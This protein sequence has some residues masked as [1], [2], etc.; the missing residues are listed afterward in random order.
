M[1]QY[2]VLLF[3]S[4][5]N[6]FLKLNL[7]LLF[8]NQGVKLIYLNTP[9]CYLQLH[10]VASS[11]SYICTTPSCTN[12]PLHMLHHAKRLQWA[13]IW[14]SV[15]DS[16]ETFHRKKY[17]SSQHLNLCLELPRLQRDIMRMK[18]QAHKFNCHI[19]F[20]L[21]RSLSCSSC[22]DFFMLVLAVA[23][24]ALFFKFKFFILWQCCPLY[25]IQCQL[26]VF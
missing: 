8:S 4:R 5:H 9:K 10:N 2:C 17:C 16:L 26:L 18:A 3:S 14:I 23:R 7:F 21:L 11:P 15:R 22:C 13:W 20:L 6:H 24:W 19:F 1:F 25:H 12:L